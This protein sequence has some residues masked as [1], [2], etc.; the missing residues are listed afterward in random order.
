MKQDRVMWASKIICT[1]VVL[2]MVTAT[3]LPLTV[4]DT[5]YEITSGEGDS[6]AGTTA[7]FGWNVSKAGDVDGDGTPD[8]IVGAPNA[9]YGGNTDCGA[10]FIFFGYEGIEDSDLNASSANVS[11]YGANAGDHFG[12]DVSD[13]GDVN[14]NYA[15]IIIGAPD[16]L[17]YGTDRNG[18]A[19]IFY[20]KGLDWE[21]VTDDGVWALSSTAANVTIDGE[22]DG[23]RFGAS[24]S[25]AGNY[26]NL[27]NDDVIVGAPNADS[28]KGRAYIFYDGSMSTSISAAN[29]DIIMNG[30]HENGKFGTSVSSAGDTDGVGG[31]EVVVGEPGSERAYVYYPPSDQTANADDPASG[32]VTPS[33]NGY[34]KTQ[35]SD[36]DY[37][38]LEEEAGG[39]SSVI[40]DDDFETD[41]GW[42]GYGG[43]GEWERAAPS[44]LGGEHGNSDPSA[45]HTSGSGTLCLGNDITGGGT[46]LGDYENTGGTTYWITSPSIDFTGKTNVHMRFWRYLNVE[47]SAYDNAYIETQNGVTGWT[48][49]WDNTDF[50]VTD[51]VWIQVIYD[52]STM[53]DNQN[54]FQ[55][56]FGIDGDSTWFFSGWNI[57]DFE[58]LT[59]TLATYDYSSGYNT[60][61]WSYDKSNEAVRPPGSG[62]A[63]AGEAAFTSANIAGTDNIR[64]STTITAGT[65][66]FQRFEINIAENPANIDGLYLEY[67]GGA[68]GTATGTNGYMWNFTS[69]AWEVWANTPMYVGGDTA[70]DVS[71]LN[72]FSNYISG[73]KLYFLAECGASDVGI[74]HRTDHVQ[75]QIFTESAIS[76]SKLEHKW[77]IPVTTGGTFYL[78]ANRTDKGEGDTLDFYYSLTGTGTVGDTGAGWVSM[79]GQITIPTTGDPD[80]YQTYSDSTLDTHTGPLYIGVV[81]ADRTGDNTLKDVLCVDHMFVRGISFKELIGERVTQSTDYTATADTAVTGT[82]TNT[83]AKT[84][85]TDDDYES[86]QEV[87]VAATYDYDYTTDE[88]FTQSES[89]TNDHTATQALGGNT[90]DIVELSMPGG[91][92]EYLYVDGWGSERTA[93]TEAGNAPY[94]NAQ[95]EPTHIISTTSDGAQSGDYTFQNSAITGTFSSSQVEFYA[96]NDDGA[97][98]DEFLVYIH[99]GTS[100]NYIGTVQPTGT[101]YAWFA[102]DTSGIL[103]TETK[104]DAAKLYVEFNRVGQTDDVRIDCARIY[105]E[106]TGVAHESLEHKWQ[107]TNT[108]LSASQYE[109]HA[110][111]GWDGAGAGDDT[112]EYY[113]SEANPPT[114]SVGDP[115]E[116]TLMFTDSTE[117]VNEQTFDL[118]NDGYTGGTFYVGVIDTASSGD[119][120]DTLIVDY[121]YVETLITPA[122]SELEHKWTFAGVSAGTDTTFYLEAYRTNLDSEDFEFYYS[123]TGAGSVSTWT[124]MPSL[125]LTKTTDDD[126]YQEFSDGTLDAFT[127]TLYVGVID[128]T[129]G[130]SNLD[131]V[132]IDHMYFRASG[133]MLDSDFGFSVGYVDNLNDDGSNTPDVLI[134]A[135]SANNGYAYGWFDGDFETMA[136]R[137]DTSQADFTVSGSSLASSNPNNNIFATSGGDLNL[138]ANIIFEDDFEDDTVGGNPDDPPWT[139]TEDADAVV[140][141]VNTIY[142]PPSDPSGQCVELADSGT[143]PVGDYCRIT[144]SFTAIAEGCVEYYLRVSNTEETDIFVKTGATNVMIMFFSGNNIYWHD[145]SNHDIGDYVIDTWYHVRLIFDCDTNK[146]DIYID[147]MVTPAKT[148]A[149]FD[150]GATDVNTIEFV[151]PTGT[152]VTAYIDKIKVYDFDTPGN[153]TSST[154]TAPYYLTAVKPY[155]NLT[156]PTGTTAWINISRDGG[157]TW[158]QSAISNGCWYT[159]PSE[160][161]GKELCYKIEMSTTHVGFTP[162]LEDITLYY[163]YCNPPD[164]TFTGSSS[165]DKFGFSVASA[166]DIDG[167]SIGDIIVGAPYDDDGGADAG[168]IFVYCGGA[169]LSGTVSAANANFTYFG[170]NAGDMLGWS[171]STAGDINEHGYD[172]VIAGAPYYD[173]SKGMAYA[174]SIALPMKITSF[175][176]AENSS[177]ALDVDLSW[178]SVKGATKYK[179][180]RSDRPWKFNWA[181]PI[182]TID[183]PATSWTDTTAARNTTNSQ[184]MTAYYYA[185]RA[186][187]P[188]GELGSFKMFAIYRMDLVKGWNLVSWFSNATQDIESEAFKNLEDDDGTNPDTYEYDKV[189]RWNPT[190]QQWESYTTDGD[191]GPFSDMAPGYAYAV[192]CNHTGGD[193]V[194]TWTYTEDFGSPTFSSADDSALGAPTNFQLARNAGNP[195]H[196]DLSWTAVGGAARY[197]IYR[198]TTKWGFDFNSPIYFTANGAEVTWTDT[199]STQ[200]NGAYNHSVYYYIVRA[201]D[202]SGDIEKNTNAVGMHR[203]D[204]MTGI[205]YISWGVMK[206]EDIDAAALASLTWGGDY[207]AVSRWNET[208]QEFNNTDWATVNDFTDFEPGY[209]YAVYAIQ[210]C[211]WTYVEYTT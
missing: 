172:D 154:T 170:E 60:D 105:W 75:V 35:A 118:D 69:G 5:L 64:Y 180:F 185:I 70:S 191:L 97:A 98:N 145:G 77:T 174:L 24:V 192:Q 144:A 197:N 74:T 188:I 13:A 130:D 27:V 103:D 45:D 82:V 162:V 115:S 31:T 108:P 198:S 3:I 139:T 17:T 142:Y 177:D 210:A 48:R 113:Y 121:L 52:V 20:G 160:A 211:T 124:P 187:N 94:L 49:L 175:T 155:W 73:G 36:D 135:P 19:Y 200:E 8:I 171:V 37:E 168:G 26:D 7:Q 90:E 184:N 42:T 140:S 85:A 112:F 193:G 161:I 147:D 41:K 91:G 157:I 80:S 34:V 173:S 109:F 21:A 119:G 71:Y 50:L 88:V 2:M 25:C 126:V 29:A 28:G 208:A 167:D 68:S 92:N 183:A 100:W 199:T 122:T 159:F 102:L 178:S 125:D 117:A 123:T 78:E 51:N 16:A 57:D 146:Y 53:A 194:I 47:N 18:S 129:S 6:G 127:G 56:R 128:A 93:W 11:I 110:F 61:K 179:I 96:N 136:S 43:G 169:Y 151:S 33:T 15:D 111:V 76:T 12:W 190:T 44:G 149:D 141:I 83:Y 209:G 38:I 86:I 14:G 1:V 165:G 164:V 55:V 195:D 181:S 58:L 81:D 65:Y 206:I 9:D 148:G 104:I 39:G 152:T 106:T 62:P 207:F 10:A 87:S 84:Q 176:I 138:S 163:E 166:G 196:V 63:V 120:K 54:A 32:T 143:G 156:T 30:K 202:A 204:F 133:A 114:T 158:N 131:T 189:E 101:I 186:E 40:W 150:T 72:G 205:N 132:Y 116:W 4:G 95:D 107:F 203:M 22:A 67:E 182:A 79:M 59:G 134:G 66:S 89:H 137:T 23:D 99:D 201:V 153:Y 46:Y